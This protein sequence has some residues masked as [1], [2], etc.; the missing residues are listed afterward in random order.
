MPWLMITTAARVLPRH[1]HRLG[2]RPCMIPSPSTLPPSPTSAP[3]RCP[4]CSWHGAGATARRAAGPL[5]C[6][7]GRRRTSPMSGGSPGSMC[8]A[9]L[10]ALLHKTPKP[11]AKA[12]FRGGSAPGGIRTP[13]RPGRNRLLYPLS[14]GRL[15]A[16]IL[17][18]GHS[19]K[20]RVPF[21]VQRLACPAIVLVRPSKSIF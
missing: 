15:D 4:V 13:N 20:V 21:E 18:G 14:Y 11:S 2:C 5:W 10:H 1:H 12:R 9:L 3:S 6:A 16:P 17:A 8:G 19:P 7:S